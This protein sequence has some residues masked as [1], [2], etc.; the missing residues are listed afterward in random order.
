MPQPPQENAT[1]GA[2]HEGIVERRSGVSISDLTGNGVSDPLIATSPNLEEALSRRAQAMALHAML[3]EIFISV[4]ETRFTLW[5]GRNCM[6]YLETTLVS[7]LGFPDFI[8]VS[9]ADHMQGTKASIFRT[10][11]YLDKV[12]YERASSPGPHGVISYEDQE[13]LRSQKR[14]IDKALNDALRYAVYAYSSRWVHLRASFVPST[15][16]QQQ[17]T[18]R[19]IAQQLQD[20]LWHKARLQIFP[21]LTNPSYRSI[22]A[23][24][25]FSLTEM[26]ARNDDP[27]INAL[28]AQ[29]LVSHFHRVRHLSAYLSTQSLAQCTSVSPYVQSSHHSNIQYASDVDDQ[30]YRH[31]RDSMLWLGILCEMSQ[32]AIQNYPMIIF[33]GNCGDEKAWNFIRQRTIIFDN[34]FRILY[35][36]LTPL[37]EDVVV[38]LL[39]HA[40]A[41]K[42]MY[43]GVINQFRES[44]SQSNH[45]IIT[46]LARKVSD[47]R[48]RFH[49]VFDQLLTKCGRDYLTMTPE[50]QLN[51]CKWG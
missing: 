43:Y 39:Q 48:Q 24:L 35:K 16:V 51:Y 4:F 28:C 36:S 40:S 10:V 1:L 50:S 12:D 33:T 38:V 5:L 11:L 25:L 17:Q 37:A 26:P 3:W 34:S 49:D 44:L 30:K 23:M 31:M 9:S 20:E 46:E 21:A 29:T 19:Q 22:L 18:S 27:G 13:E 7:T 15:R 41:C 32:S 42:T 45:E 8:L 14:K 47:E 2:V 6:P